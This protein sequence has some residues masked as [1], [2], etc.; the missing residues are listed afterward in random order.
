MSTTE[1]NHI[2][3]YEGQFGSWQLKIQRQSFTTG[4]LV[5]RFDKLA[6]SWHGLLQRLGYHAAYEEMWRKFLHAYET[7]WPHQGPA[8]LDCGAGTGPFSA[9]FGRAWSGPVALSAVDASP[10]MLREASRRYR[11][12]GICADLQRADMSKLPYRENRFDLVMS[13]HVLEHLC[14]PTAALREMYRVLQPGGWLVI[15]ATR[16]SALGRYIHFKWRTHLFKPSQ[17]RNWV[18]AAGFSNP[19]STLPL[20][21]LFGQTSL[22]CVCQ[23]PLTE[24]SN[25]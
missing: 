4:E 5:T 21:G 1:N 18:R 15:G 13:A 10:L 14:D 3:F 8:V 9:A 2:P 19:P 11:K 24:R 16:D 22:L 23:K 20:S 25:A 7:N 17:M 6:K 12:Q